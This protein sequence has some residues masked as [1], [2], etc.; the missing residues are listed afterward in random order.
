MKKKRFPAIFF[1]AVLC[2]AVGGGVG[3][4]FGQSGSLSKTSTNT[5]ETEYYDTFYGEIT[6]ISDSTIYVTG[7]DCN[8]INYR[9][10]FSIPLP[11]TAQILWRGTEIELSDLSVGDTIS[12][13]HSG[14]V[15]ETSPA[16]IVSAKR[17]QLLK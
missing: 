4:H 7:L 15:L 10:E 12:I 11:E 9:D 2:L 16:C 14:D 5:T 17:I 6:K 1:T 3:Y 8:D 13:T